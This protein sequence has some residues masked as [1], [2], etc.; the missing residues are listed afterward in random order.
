[1]T[2][3]VTT[4]AQRRPLAATV[5]ALIAALI[6]SG[7][8]ARLSTQLT[9]DG[10]WAGTR[11]ITAT[12]PQ[13]DVTDKL[14][15]DITAVDAAIN[16]HLPSQLTYSGMSAS[17][18]DYTGTF[19][20]TFDSKEDYQKK[21]TELLAASG[22][23]ITPEIIWERPD[24]E[25]VSGIHLEENFGDKDLLG[26][27]GDALVVEGILD[28]SRKTSIF[29]TA[30]A[31][32][33]TLD[34]ADY[35]SEEHYNRSLDVDTVQDNGVSKVLVTV[36]LLP[37]S[38]L[39][40]TAY[41]GFTDTTASPKLDLLDS[42]LEAHKPD[43]AE[44]SKDLS[45]AKGKVRTG[46]AVTFTATDIDS[47]NASLAELLGGS[48][49]PL[50]L[51]QDGL[52][53]SVKGDISC[54]NVCSPKADPASLQL[55]VPQTWQLS[56]APHVGDVSTGTAK[57]EALTIT[58]E[59]S[60]ELTAQVSLPVTELHVTTS[61]SLTGTTTVATAFSF[62]KAAVSATGMSSE[63][64][65]TAVGLS[66]ATITEG[67][68]TVTATV[69]FSGKPEELSA[70]IAEALPGSIYGT[71]EATGT[72]STAYRAAIRITLTSE[73][74]TLSKDTVVDATFKAPFGQK[75]SASRA[76]TAYDDFGELLT[77]FMPT[78][79]TTLKEIN[80]SNDAGREATVAISPLM[81]GRDLAVIATGTY[82]GRTLAG[83]ILIAVLLVILIALA[84]LAVVFRKRIAVLLSRSKEKSA[85]AAAQARAQAA[86]INAQANAQAAAQ[87][88]QQSTGVPVASQPAPP[89]APG[90]TTATGPSV[91]PAGA[92]APAAPT[93]PMPPA[94]SGQTAYPPAPPAAPV[95]PA[96]APAPPAPATPAAPAPAAPPQGDN[97][98]DY[99]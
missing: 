19:T 73:H 61:T 4:T 25:L 98:A 96:A 90:Q 15:G 32:T 5:L 18:E 85:A 12:V 6:L 60:F 28:E 42:Y 49:T 69:S 41:I 72:F 89:T 71:T 76:T 79:A 82:T 10:S 30:T 65:A 88:G 21:V 53:V 68:D 97:E 56:N 54:A 36:S 39:A 81:D 46:R 23:G 43:G 1:M 59:G 55:V 48:G 75:V 77:D 78:D 67:E 66:D 35:E 40:T 37:D 91:Q 22:S 2:S 51:S 44:I 83:W 34:G 14:T 95:T 31:P 94:P 9:L 47:L 33:V 17:G 3:T 58:G 45:D 80:K 24:S 20:L 29:D 64:A 63:D 52:S 16:N 92:A 13:Q 86:A 84:V 38:Y 70:A 7:C 93:A 57:S 99:L 27:V 8:G 50:S 74:L 26:W 87:L 11:V 62:P